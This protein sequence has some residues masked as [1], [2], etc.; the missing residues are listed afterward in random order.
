MTTTTLQF[1]RLERACEAIAAILKL[2][3]RADRRIVLQG[4]LNVERGTFGATDTIRNRPLGV[5]EAE[6]QRAERGEA[7]GTNAPVEGA[8]SAAI[9]GAPSSAPH[10]HRCE[11]P[12][13]SHQ[14]PCV[15]ARCG[16]EY[17]RQQPNAEPVDTN[18]DAPDDGVAF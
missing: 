12:D 16:A 13:Q 7:T 5:L 9:A 1:P 17:S 15:C 6:R 14:G 11:H 4:L 3:P 8:F 10:Q 2:L 18:A